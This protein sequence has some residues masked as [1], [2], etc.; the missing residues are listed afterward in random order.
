MIEK[1]EFQADTTERSLHKQKPALREQGG[2]LFGKE[3]G[4]FGF[5]YLI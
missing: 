4:S 5:S 3:N 1:Q 2:F